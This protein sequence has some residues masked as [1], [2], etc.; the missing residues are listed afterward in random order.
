MRLFKEQTSTYLETLENLMDLIDIDGNGTIEEEELQNFPEVKLL[1]PD[2]FKE[3]GLDSITEKDIISA[4][5]DLEKLQNVVL[6]LEKQF[7]HVE[8]DKFLIQFKVG[9]VSLIF[10]FFFDIL[11]SSSWNVFP[12]YCIRLL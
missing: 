8:K 9:A 2:I 5:P 3:S 1:L 4:K 7:E 11:T 10:V 6:E 12:I